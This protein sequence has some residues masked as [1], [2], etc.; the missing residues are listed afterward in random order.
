MHLIQFRS[1]KE[2][3]DHIVQNQH[4]PGQLLAIQIGSGSKLLCKNRWAQF[5]QNAPDLLPVSHCQTQ[6]RSSTDGPDILSKTSLD[7]IWFWLTVSGLG[8]MDLVQKQAGVQESLGLLLANAS[9]L[10]WIHSHW[11]WHIY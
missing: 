9:E 5:W 10:V 6:L 2:G 7:L 1:F 11:I 3:L 4:G 8:Q